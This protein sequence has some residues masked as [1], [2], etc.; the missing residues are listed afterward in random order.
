M[1]FLTRQLVHESVALRRLR[2]ASFGC[3][4][5]TLLGV[6]SV[7][8]HC[9]VV[10]DGAGLRSDAAAFMTVGGE[11]TQLPYYADNALGF[12]A[13]VT[14]QPRVLVG[15]EFRAGAYPVSARYVQMPFTAGYRVAGHSFFGFPYSPFAYIGGGVSRSQDK[16]TGHLE[17]AP[18]F[19]RCWQSDVGLDRKYGSFAWRV[20]QVSYR[21]TFTPLHTLRSVGLSTGIVYRF[22]RT[23]ESR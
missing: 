21:Q 10:V 6:G 17:Y 13:G 16:G 15:M 9:Q 4:V 7:R 11:N 20:A 14:Y 18:Q 12:D 5:W 23:G 19:E 1:A 8:A 3:V 2:R 22:K